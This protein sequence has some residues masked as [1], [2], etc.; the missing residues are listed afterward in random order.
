MYVHTYSQDGG[1]KC[2]LFPA[3]VVV[4]QESGRSEFSGAEEGEVAVISIRS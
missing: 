3:D 2:P 4:Q 1:L